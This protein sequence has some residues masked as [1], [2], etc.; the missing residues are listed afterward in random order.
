MTGC[1]KKRMGGFSL[2]TWVVVFMCSATVDLLIISAWYRSGLGGMQRSSNAHHS[3]AN[4]N[5]I[6]QVRGSS[7]PSTLNQ[8][9]QPILVCNDTENVKVMPMGTFPVVGLASFPGSGNSWM[10]S[11]I[12]RATGYATG[13]IY[14]IPNQEK[15]FVGEMRNVAAGE[16]IVFKLHD[17]WKG[18]TNKRD[19]QISIQKAILIIRNPYRAL[20]EEFNQLGY[21]KQRAIHENRFRSEA[22]SKFMT[23]TFKF[24]RW[25]KLSRTLMD[26]CNHHATSVPCKAIH[27]VYYENLETD[28]KNE[29]LQIIKFLDVQVDERRLSCAV[30]ASDTSPHRPLKQ[31]H[32]SFDPFTEEHRARIDEDMKTFHQWLDSEGL[33]RPPPGFSN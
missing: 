4:L 11:M 23:E 31:S 28:L 20:I 15:D 9:T 12:E 19:G 30:A 1:L 17:Y 24:S 16:T 27:I 8:T 10:R 14:H 29:L 33:P 26:M 22:W 32:L 3:A 18:F 2:R 13:D 6:S 21:G 25:L 5:K 7:S